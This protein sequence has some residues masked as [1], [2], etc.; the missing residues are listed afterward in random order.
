MTEAKETRT[1]AFEIKFVVDVQMGGRICAWARTF[2]DADPHGTVPFATSIGRTTLYFDTAEGHV[3]HRRGSTPGP[4]TASAG[5]RTA[6]SVQTTGRDPI[7]IASIAAILAVVVLA[8]SVWPARAATQIDPLV[9]LRR[10][11]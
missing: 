9:A 10:E 6:I 1:H 7:I 5:M 8:A 4:N 11:Q 2:L 3:I